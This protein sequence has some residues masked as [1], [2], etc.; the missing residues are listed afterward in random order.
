MSCEIILRSIKGAHFASLRPRLSLL[1]LAVKAYSSIEPALTTVI[2]R[3]NTS[4]RSFR[5]TDFAKIL[6]GV[7]A[8]Q[9]LCLLKVR[10]SLMYS[11]ESCLPVPLPYIRKVFI[12]VKNKEA[13]VLR[14]TGTSSSKYGYF[15]RRSDKNCP[16][17]S[18]ARSRERIRQGRTRSTP[19]PCELKREKSAFVSD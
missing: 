16:S 17:Y 13:V 8:E 1:N 5:R 14:D 4:L 2:K 6:A 19:T 7:A 9:R 10:G 11:S 18:I 15:V 12:Y 3:I